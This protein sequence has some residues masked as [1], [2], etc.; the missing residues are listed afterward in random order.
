M[1][2][3]IEY[4][5]KVDVLLDK[6]N[7]D[8]S[9]DKPRGAIA[10]FIS[11]SDF[12]ESSEIIAN[13]AYLLASYGSTVCVVDFKVFYPN[14][15]DWLGGVSADRKGEG[16]IRLLNSERTEVRN[17]ARKTD[18][19]NV[20]LISP[21]PN[22]DIEDFLSYSVEDVGRIIGLLKETFD[23]VLI[24]IPNNPAFEFCIGAMMYCHKGFFIASERTDAPRNIQKLLEFALKITGNAECFQ[25]IILSHQQ[26]LIFDEK[27]FTDPVLRYGKNSAG[28]RIIARL[29]LSKESLQCALDG[30][31]FIRDGSYISKKFM[32]EGK[33]LTSEL[34]SIAGIIWEGQRDADS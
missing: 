7:L 1:D 25:N 21:S 22:D 4:I 30:N 3:R 16:L 12:S 28:P 5:E 32:K 10:G 26:G 18:D 17:I 14:L 13:L 31:V 27:T 11:V 24:D 34:M 19:K 23:I 33:R 6:L 15:V 29:P 8:F 20:F 2:N 9:Y